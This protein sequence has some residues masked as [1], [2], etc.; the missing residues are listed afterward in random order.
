[1]Q[2]QRRL[3]WRSTLLYS[4]T[5]N[6]SPSTR[7]QRLCVLPCTQKCCPLA[8]VSPRELDEFTEFLPN[9]ITRIATCTPVSHACGVCA[10]CCACGT[11]TRRRRRHILKQCDIDAM[12]TCNVRFT[13]FKGQGKTVRTRLRPHRTRRTTQRCNTT[14]TQQTRPPPTKTSTA[15]STLCRQHSIRS[16]LQRWVRPPS[17]NTANTSTRQRRTPSRRTEES[18][19]S[20]VFSPQSKRHCPLPLTACGVTARGGAQQKHYPSREPQSRKLQTK[21]PPP[22]DRIWGHSGGGGP[23]KAPSTS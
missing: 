18:S 4:R 23:T 3:L 8:S 9:R 7:T 14:R 15:L 22:A 6:P 13:L 10:V 21:L 12:G 16:T 5:P 19:S 11:T 20:S 2:L 1:M 17:T